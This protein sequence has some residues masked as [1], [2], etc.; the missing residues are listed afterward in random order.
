MK[1]KQNK[2]KPTRENGIIMG[3]IMGVVIGAMLT[4]STGNWWWLGITFCLSM[5]VGAV[6]ERIGK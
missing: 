4:A 2:L 6:S 5:I 3:M 1:V